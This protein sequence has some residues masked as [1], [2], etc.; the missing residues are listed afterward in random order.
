MPRVYTVEFNAVALS[1]Q[2]DLISLLAGTNQPVIMMELGL[3][4]STDV[5]DA[6]EKEWNLVLKSGATTAGS[7]GSSY[8][9]VPIDFGDSAAGATART[10]DTTIASAGTI[11]THLAWNWNVR[12][13]FQYIWMPETRIVIRPARRIVF[14]LATTPNAATTC[15]GYAVFQEI[16]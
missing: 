8:T 3:S 15:S 6:N 14:G 11:V 5:S 7:A 2:Q 10:N 1:A 16:G 13:P 4:Q 9:P 12:V